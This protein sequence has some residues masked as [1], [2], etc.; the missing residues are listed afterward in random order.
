[1]YWTSALGRGYCGYCFASTHQGTGVFSITVRLGKAWSWV[2][3][4]HIWSVFQ[5]LHGGLSIFGKALVVT[6]GISA[7]VAMVAVNLKGPH[8][9]EPSTEEVWRTSFRTQMIPITM[10][11]MLCTYLPNPNHSSSHPWLLFIVGNLLT[12]EG[13]MAV[14]DGHPNKL[15]KDLIYY[16]ERK[17]LPAMKLCVALGADVNF[18]DPSRWVISIIVV[19]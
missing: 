10:L 1:M 3:I 12:I 19:C 2:F 9:D 11:T 13:A 8:D 14:V 6:T 5:C 17:N 7:S 16:T 4:S 18:Q 15:G